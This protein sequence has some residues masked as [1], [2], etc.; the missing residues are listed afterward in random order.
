MD[1]A[2]FTMLLFSVSR[3]FVYWYIGCNKLKFMSTFFWCEMIQFYL[4]LL[5]LFPHIVL[6][7]GKIQFFHHWL[8]I[9][10]FIPVSRLV[11]RKLITI[12]GKSEALELQLKKNKPHR[13]IWI[14]HH[15]K[16]GIYLLFHFSPNL[17]WTHYKY[18]WLSVLFSR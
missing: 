12:F 17:R 11:F 3:F 13:I 2:R 8:V 16:A 6:F 5:F 1:A 9:C 4:H 10:W 7:C 15:S 18:K 14:N